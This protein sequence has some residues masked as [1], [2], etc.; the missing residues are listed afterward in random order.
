MPLDAV[1]AHDKR[2]QKGVQLLKN[3]LREK[4]LFAST[5]NGDAP[6]LKFKAE[7]FL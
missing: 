3:L 4:L 5:P 7:L 1:P 6:L 2:F